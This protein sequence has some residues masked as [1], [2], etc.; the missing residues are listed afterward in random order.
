M[1]RLVVTTRAGSTEIAMHGKRDV[2]LGD[3]AERFNVRSYDDLQVALGAGND[4]GVLGTGNDLLAG[5]AGHDRLS[6]GAGDD[7][8]LGGVGNDTLTGGPG[9]DL[10]VILPDEAAQDEITDFEI[11]VDTLALPGFDGL[12]A[13]TTLSMT[14]ASGGLRVDLGGEQ[15]VLLRGVPS[16][17]ALASSDIAFNA[18]IHGVDATGPYLGT[19]LAGGVE[20]SGL[21]LWRW[22]DD[23]RRRA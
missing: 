20:P 16:R 2:I 4:V 18:A 6:A 14:P 1:A 22:R 21:T 15:S 9:K 7:T 8:L 5:G 19:A 23:Q 13:T 11:G 3:G 10:F 12:A 17:E